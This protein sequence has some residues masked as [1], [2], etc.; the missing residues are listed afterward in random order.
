M[1]DMTD[2]LRSLAEIAASRHPPADG[3]ESA[4]YVVATG[5]SG[6]PVYANRNERLG[7]DFS[8]ERL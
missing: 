1:T 5:G 3:V 8:V 4:R 2:Q 6:T 7:I